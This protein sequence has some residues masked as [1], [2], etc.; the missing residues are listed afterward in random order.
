LG[1]PIKENRKSTY[2]FL[3]LVEK[4]QFRNY[5]RKRRVLNQLLPRPQPDVLKQISEKFRAQD[6]EGCP[7]QGVPEMEAYLIPGRAQLL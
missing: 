1:K 2:G 7:N 6:Q 3:S 4:Y 5:T